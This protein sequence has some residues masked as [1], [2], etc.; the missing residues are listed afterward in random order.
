MSDERTGI[1]PADLQNLR[2]QMLQSQASG[3]SVPPQPAPIPPASQP[4]GQG[5][6]TQ[7]PMGVQPNMTAPQTGTN[8]MRARMLAARGGAPTQ[9]TR[10]SQGAS[11]D[12]NGQIHQQPQPQ[13]Q[14]P[15][16][17]ATSTIINTTQ[18]PTND[19]G[20][21]S[22][23]KPKIPM[24]PKIALIIVGVVIVLGVLLLIFSRKPAGE[25]PVQDEPQAT[26]G[27]DLVWIEPEVNAGTFYTQE[28]INRL[29]EVG[30]T[31]TEIEEF[32]LNGEDVDTKVK[33]AEAIRDAWI[34]E[35]VAPLYD[36]TSQEYK[37]MINQTWLAL[38]KRTDIDTWETSASY[39][40]ERKNLDYEK[41]EVHGNQLFIKIYLDDD[42]H[43]DW[44]FLN[45]QPDEWAKL[46]DKGNVVVNYTYCTRYI[47]STDGFLVED[48]NNTFII[49]ATLEI[50]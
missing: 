14:A 13:P 21:G 10:L 48:F 38:P 40:T 43:E 23:D 18:V 15:M 29:R 26:E 4:M 9:P 12:P 49:S 24:S 45:V 32:A 3:T 47:T 33:E 30:Y 42:K 35:A 1:N 46:K 8:D 2:A 37:D 25:E 17:G 16:P 36:A 39:Y 41:I 11:Y 50:I 31:G 5:V 28:Q 19:T 34:Q 20:N 7:Q 22:G 44:F 6:V 27:D